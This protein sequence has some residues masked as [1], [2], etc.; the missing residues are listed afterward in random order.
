MKKTKFG[1]IVSLILSMSSAALLIFQEN[2]KQLKNTLHTLICPLTEGIFISMA[3]VIYGYLF[4]KIRQHRRNK[5][6]VKN[7][8]KNL[9]RIERTKKEIFIPTFLFLSFSLFW[10][11]PDAIMFIHILTGK[12]VSNLHHSITYDMFS[13]VI[14]SDGIIFIF[15]SKHAR[16]LVLKKLQRGIIQVKWRRCN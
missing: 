2:T 13:L 1:I 6:C 12:E 8:I 14:T 3:I 7:G 4:M 15:A 5:T 16:K 10:I 9:R 11:L